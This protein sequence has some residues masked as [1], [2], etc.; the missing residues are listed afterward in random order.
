MLRAEQ[1]IDTCVG[2][3]EDSTTRVQET[4]FG[5]PFE[6]E[7]F[8]LPHDEAGLLSMLPIDEEGRCGTEFCITLKPCPRV[9]VKY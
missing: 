8:D 9:C 3:E 4:L 5:E 6:M 7:N 2:G 1:S